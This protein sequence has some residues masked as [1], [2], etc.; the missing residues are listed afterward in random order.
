MAACAAC[1]SELTGSPKFCPECGSRLESSTPALGEV[2]KT[3]TVLFCDV[4][5]STALAERLDA[6]AVRGL[7]SR[8]FAA[9][10]RVIERH[11][12]TV[13][14]FIG[15]ALMAVF[16]IPTL[17]EDDALR[18]VRAAAEMR[19]AL[20]ALNSELARERGVEIEART[21]V[22]T[23]EVVAGDA[24]TGETL[25]TGDTVNTAARLEQAA[26]PGEILIGAP[27]YRLVRDA[28]TVDPIEPVSAKGKRLRVAAY[29]LVSVTPRAEAH[30]RRLDAPLIGRQRELAR[31]Q[32]AYHDAVGERRC[33][34][35]TLLGSAGVGKS[36]LVREFL[37]ALESEALIVRGRCLPYGEGITYWPLAEALREAAGIADADDRD[38][39]RRKLRKLLAGERDAELLAARLA[40]AVGLS[41]EPA[42][43][44]EV[45][46]AVRRTLE[47]LAQAR[48]LVVV[49][50][51][52]HWAEPVFL[53]LIDHLAD[54]SREAPLLVLCPARPELLDG[55]SGWGGGK[56]N[57]TII[58]LEPLPPHAATRLIDALPGG[59]A[60]PESLRDR[61]AHVAEGNPLF[62]EEL[63]GM[64]ID[65]GV[66]SRVDG[67]W[68]VRGDVDRLEIP[69][70][71]SALLAA[72]LQRLTDAERHAAQRAAV[73]GRIFEAE[74]VAELTPDS[75]RPQLSDTIMALV[76]K[77]VVRPERSELTL[78]DAFKFRHILIRDAAYEALSKR[79]RSVLH[80]RVAGWLERIAG[81]RVAEVDEILGY[82]LEQ[83]S[84]YRREL[85]DVGAVVDRLDRRAASRLA[86]AGER[87]FQRDDPAAVTLL[88]RA[89]ELAPRHP[90]VR[91]RLAL[92]SIALAHSGDA[93]RAREVAEGLIEQGRADG[94][95]RLVAIGEVR[96]AE[97]TKRGADTEPIARRAISVL[98]R[99]GDAKA[100][101]RAWNLLEAA[102][103]EQ[104]RAE[105]AMRAAEEAARWAL[106]AGD[107]RE[108]ARSLHGVLTGLAAGPTPLPEAVRRSE[109]IVADSTLQPTF[110]QLCLGTHA[111]L[112]A[113][114]GRPNDARA[115]Q[116]DIDRI[117]ESVDTPESARLLCTLWAA[118][119]DLAMGDPITAEHRLRQ[120][121]PVARKYDQLEAPVLGLLAESLLDAARDAEALVLAQ[122]AEEVV[123]AAGE[124]ARNVEGEARLGRV[125]GEALSR[126]GDHP[127]ALQA[128]TDA[129]EAVRHSDWIALTAEIALTRASVLRRAGQ[130]EASKR[131]AREALDL[132]TAKG[133]RSGIAR[134]EQFLRPREQ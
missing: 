28:V 14:K 112:L 98:E 59:T 105:A 89:H 70:T 58:L 17:H 31:L 29:R 126:R 10:R 108:Y 65:E 67:Q 93:A 50:E 107:R 117:S 3:I 53:D 26:R 42:A 122:Q 110:Y 69:P 40:S 60:L 87:A 113:M 44:A 97:E 48:P 43:Q 129:A 92:L 99:A 36:R 130:A 123:R 55:R 120:V 20:A 30:A 13:E 121:L 77:D 6:E 66:L 71:I 82:H 27:T 68:R 104:G 80:E 51:D 133:H 111:L 39:A 86:S 11:G 127:R 54:W 81:D 78:G 18:A 8:Y 23:G 38:R 37:L 16:G 131:A 103:E 85:G 47:H 84:R 52:I 5:G 64:L 91:E 75:L 35:F 74:A 100:A 62:V 118:D 33:E 109:A 22:N 106:T 119:A 1:G 15:D 116:S 114:T 125:V 56:L 45:S 102:L 90:H 73:V 19:E 7:M 25:A 49:W 4:V 12:G 63:L 83:A 95:E 9:M 96:L 134:A 132:F 46:W 21:G 76:R 124:G 24:S 2:R 94:D 79:E 34:L 128:I 88:G 57:A 72:R 101:A 61:I 115:V 41:D 32:Q